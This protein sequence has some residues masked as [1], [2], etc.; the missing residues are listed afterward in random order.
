MNRPS[1]IIG[2]FEKLPS[3]ISDP[4]DYTLSPFFRNMY[5][6]LADIGSSIRF[7]RGNA[8]EFKQ[9]L[10]SRKCIGANITSPHKQKAVEIREELSDRAS[11][12]GSVNTIYVMENFVVT[13]QTVVDW[14]SG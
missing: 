11:G 7:S 14:S 3:Y 4:L 5:L 12:A 9:L 10:M 13:A 2:T 6:V 1:P 8:E